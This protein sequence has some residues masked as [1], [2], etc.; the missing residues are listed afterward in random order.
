MPRTARRNPARKP[1]KKIRD[2][3][4]ELQSWLPNYDRGEKEY[5]QLLFRVLASLPGGD[6]MA[7][8]G[9]EGWNLGW[10]EMNQLADVLTAI[11]SKTDV[12]DIC[13]ALLNE[14]REDEEPEENPRRRAGARLTREGGYN[15]WKNYET[16]NVAL[17]ID[18]EEP[19]YRAKQRH[20]KDVG[21]FT[22]ASVEKFVKRLMPGGTPDFKGELGGKKA[23]AKVDW[24]EVAD[25]FNEE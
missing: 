25:N 6:E 2:M 24:K 1:T 11:E 5:P 19:M 23:Y 7:D 20:L 12:E 21:K 17:W 3:I 4:A 18:N 15:G 8:V 16:W 22:A 13:S 10:Q 9:Y 14:G